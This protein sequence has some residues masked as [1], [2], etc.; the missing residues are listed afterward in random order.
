[1]L[2]FLTLEARL[3]FSMDLRLLGE[4]ELSLKLFS[5]V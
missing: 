4:G 1:M 2:L 3:R 5:D